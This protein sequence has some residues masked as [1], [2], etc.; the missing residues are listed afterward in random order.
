V[1]RR[2]WWFSVIGAGCIGLAVSVLFPELEF[3]ERALGAA[4]LV[5]GLNF[6]RIGWEE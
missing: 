5:L 4:M 3:W 2:S 1:V 6:Y